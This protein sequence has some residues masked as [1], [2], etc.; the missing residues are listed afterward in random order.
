M[1]V[2][3]EGEKEYLGKAYWAENHN[4]WSF[5]TVFEAFPTVFEAVTAVSSSHLLRFSLFGCSF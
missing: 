3:V 2:I 5:A 4:L 1:H